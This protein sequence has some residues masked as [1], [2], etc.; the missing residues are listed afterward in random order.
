MQTAGS[1]LDRGG[2]ESTPGLGRRRVPRRLF[3]NPVGLLISGEYLIERARQL[4][5][6][7]MMIESDRPLAIDQM[8]V[9][10]FF[11]P[12]RTSPVVVRSAV[13][14]KIPSKE[15][16]GLERYGIEF[17]N[18]GFAYKREIRNFVAAAS[19]HETA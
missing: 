17:L 7:G 16:N 1:V 12:G 9:V 18:L 10:S 2:V 4:G 15:A 8:I 19:G 14:S 3:D 11:L 6:G 5:E 13:R